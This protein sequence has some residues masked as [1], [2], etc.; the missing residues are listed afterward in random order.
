L[1]NGLVEKQ[2]T[3]EQPIGYISAII[4]AIEKLG[5]GD[6]A[7]DIMRAKYPREE[8][9]AMERGKDVKNEADEIFE[10][11]QPVWNGFESN[12]AGYD[13]EIKNLISNAWVVGIDE[14]YLK[15][16][17]VKAISSYHDFGLQYS[18]DFIDWLIENQSELHFSNFNAWIAKVWYYQIMITNLSSIGDFLQTGVLEE[19]GIRSIGEM[20]PEIRDDE[21]DWQA[22]YGIWKNVLELQSTSADMK[23][24]KNTETVERILTIFSEWQEF[25]SY[26]SF[27]L[28]EIEKPYFPVKFTFPKWI[29]EKMVISPEQIPRFELLRQKLSLEYDF[30]QI[31]LH[32]P[33]LSSAR[34][35]LLYN[36]LCQIIT[37]ERKFKTS[38]D[39]D[40]SE[41]LTYGGKGD[42]FLPSSTFEPVS[43]VEKH[44]NGFT[45]DFPNIIRLGI[46]SEKKQRELGKV[47]T[48]KMYDDLCAGWVDW[49]NGN[50]QPVYIHTTPHCCINF[51][52]FI[53][54]I[55]SKTNAIFLYYDFNSNLDEDLFFLSFA[56]ERNT[57]IITRD[58]FANYKEKVSHKAFKAISGRNRMTPKWNKKKGK[59]EFKLYYK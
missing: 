59:I 5:Y 30:S 25:S 53:N 39:D 58:G 40:L 45:L 46:P 49:I 47:V 15:K 31:A 42:Y 6:T 24:G 14:L 16:I 57:W 50:Q 55:A 48:R 7:M 29:E 54:E 43:V 37:S 2:E 8:F 35:V 17:M 34:K 51:S 32:W 56:L 44:P 3:S 10:K 13:L 33:E 12:M 11:Y 20:D 52:P 22:A 1:G 18:L 19:M 23:P 26:I 38:E 41:K 9:W 4:L 27:L 36:H 28:N 21:I